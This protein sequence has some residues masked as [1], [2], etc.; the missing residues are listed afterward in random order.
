[1][2][3]SEM[4]IIGMGFHV[5]GFT[6]VESFMKGL[7]VSKKAFKSGLKNEGGFI[8][9]R[10]IL[11][12]K[13]MREAFLDAKLTDKEKKE[14]A[15]IW[16]YANHPAE[17]CF[18]VG[19]RAAEIA[20]HFGLGPPAYNIYDGENSIFRG[21][22]LANSIIVEKAATIVAICITPPLANPIA[23]GDG[24][25]VEGAV[26]LLLKDKAGAIADG[27]KIYAGLSGLTIVE[28]VNQK[29]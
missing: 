26:V 3:N 23:M 22:A 29:R 4:A 5:G 17:K 27:N 11:L 14:T 9:A 8:F 1:M 20:E 12:E 18:A 6:C 7:V 16:H 21:L 2:I 24:K 19:G 10:D 13:T 25:E 28:A 15:F